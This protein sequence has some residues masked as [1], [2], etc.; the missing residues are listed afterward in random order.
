VLIAIST[1]GNSPN[2]LAAVMAAR[3]RGCSVLGF[4][5]A[6]GKRLAGLSDVC[7]MVPSERTA[8]IQEVHITVAHILCEM[9]D[10]AVETGRIKIQ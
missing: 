3:A 9:V 6:R 10:Q 1:S 8:R 2:V 7:I 5:G 4:T